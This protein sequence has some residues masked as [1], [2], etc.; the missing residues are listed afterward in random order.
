VFFNDAR[1]AVPPHVER[2][3]R[4]AGL[5]IDNVRWCDWCGEVVSAVTHEQISHLD[6][7][8]FDTL[9]PACKCP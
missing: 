4:D 1:R 8:G 7:V 3:L 6:A 2:C 5:T 9:C